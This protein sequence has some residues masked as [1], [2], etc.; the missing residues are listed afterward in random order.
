MVSALHVNLISCW[1]GF[2]LNSCFYKSN[3]DVNSSYLFC[4]VTFVL[5]SALVICSVNCDYVKC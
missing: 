5:S 2:L 1:V 4:A 3:S